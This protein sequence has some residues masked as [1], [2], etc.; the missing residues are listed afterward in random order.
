MAIPIEHLIL[1]GT[2]MGTQLRKAKASFTELFVNPVRQYL[3]GVPGHKVETAGLVRTILRKR[4][5]KP[6]LD[7]DKVIEDLRA[8]IHAGKV[9]AEDLKTM[10]LN[11]TLGVG[12]PDMVAEAT[13]AAA[14]KTK[15]DYFSLAVE[16]ED[17]SVQWNGVS[18]DSIGKLTEE[19]ARLEDLDAM[20][21]GAANTPLRP[22]VY[23]R[24]LELG[25]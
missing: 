22:D 14:G 15:G 20:V 13:A 17:N 24:I 5:P 11:G 12:D 6:K 23:A 9:T 18:K 8:L 10:V 25:K 2:A 3:E 1:K 19:Y 4:N 21:R 16:V 7:E